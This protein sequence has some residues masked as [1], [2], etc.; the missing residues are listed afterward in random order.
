[1]CCVINPYIH[2]SLNL[3]TVEIFLVLIFGFFFSLNHLDLLRFFLSFLLIYLLFSFI[4]FFQGVCVGRG[5][6][7]IY[8]KK[9]K[10]K[11]Y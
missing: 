3:L 8:P 7:E 1:M 9:I 6:R 4:F 2:V 10:K 5:E 11:I